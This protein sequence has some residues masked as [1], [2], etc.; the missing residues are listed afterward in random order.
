MPPE[1]CLPSQIEYQ[2][3]D[4]T[5]THERLGKIDTEIGALKEVISQL[6]NADSQALGFQIGGCSNV[7]VDSSHGCPLDMSGTVPT[8]EP[9][10]AREGAAERQQAEAQDIGAEH[11]GRGIAGADQRSEGPDLQRFLQRGSTTHPDQLRG[12]SLRAAA[13]GCCALSVD[14]WVRKETCAMGLRQVGVAN[15]REYETEHLQRA[16]QAGMRRNKLKMQA[17]RVC[18]ADSLAA[19][20]SLELW[21]NSVQ[22]ATTCS[23]EIAAQTAS[24][25]VC[26]LQ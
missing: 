23:C 19:V 17:S 22:C 11:K 12:A 16:E 6:C 9:A 14:D 25:A 13:T 1:L 18:A 24:G 4:I 7:Q 21:V 26:S 8:C 3:Q 15:I 20:N 5:A 2:Q 10:G